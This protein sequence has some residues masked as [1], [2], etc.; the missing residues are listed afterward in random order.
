M[1][2]NLKNIRKDKGYQLCKLRAYKHNFIA[3]DWDKVG[4]MSM[5]VG[6][7]LEK[8]YTDETYAIG[9]HR[10]PLTNINP[11]FNEGIINNS[12]MHEELPNLEYTVSMISDLAVM[13]ASLKSTYDYKGAKGAFIIKI[14]K[15]YIDKEDGD[16]K[17]IYYQ[18]ENGF[19]YLLPEF[20]YGYIPCEESSI[21]EFILN[22]NY[23]DVHT[24]SNE[25]YIYD[26]SVSD[27]ITKISRK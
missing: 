4:Y 24:Y 26:S 25:G 2:I 7:E 23:R 16:I 22:P 17:P 13:H 12:I 14:P 15:S 8:L 18:K 5:E 9:L 3:Q 1:K 11:I 6:K 19:V 27:K 21:K 10:C 20:I